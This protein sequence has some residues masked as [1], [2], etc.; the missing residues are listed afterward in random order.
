MKNV[1]TYK[2][3]SQDLLANVDDGSNTI[4]INDS[5]IPSTDWVGTGTYTT[6]VTGTTISIERISDLSGNI[7]LQKQAENEYALV[8]KSEAGVDNVLLWG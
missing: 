6:V 3:G 4:Y 8:R 1:L 5:L 2:N 7:M